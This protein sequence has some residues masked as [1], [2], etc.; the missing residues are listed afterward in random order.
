MR[1]WSGCCDGDPC[2]DDLPP[3][4]RGNQVIW[5]QSRSAQLPAWS[6]LLGQASGDLQA[7]SPGIRPLTWRLFTSQRYCS[8]R[9]R[10]QGATKQLPFTILCL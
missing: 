1:C 6:V 4:K 9:W 7:L 3:D 2:S 5:G 10:V 8:G